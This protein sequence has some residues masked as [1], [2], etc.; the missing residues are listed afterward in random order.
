MYLPYSGVPFERVFCT[1]KLMY[2]SCTCRR[3]RT[4]YVKLLTTLKA[5]CNEYSFSF[6]LGILLKP[7]LHYW[8]SGCQEK[9]Q[10]YKPTMIIL[11]RRGTTQASRRARNSKPHPDDQGWCCN[12]CILELY[13]WLKFWSGPSCSKGG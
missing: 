13:N 12:T 10:L 5:K 2:C 1:K 4:F 6:S 7:I 3:V 8:H 11:Q 9:I